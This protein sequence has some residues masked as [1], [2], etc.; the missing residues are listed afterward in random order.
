MQKIG[1]V[2]IGKL[3]KHFTVQPILYTHEIDKSNK[4][5]TILI[6]DLFGNPIGSLTSLTFFRAKALQKCNFLR[7]LFRN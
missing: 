3:V 2:G 4:S 6:F 5:V 1:I 7:K